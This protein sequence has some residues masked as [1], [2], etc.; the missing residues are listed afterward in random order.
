M[1]TRKEAETLMAVAVQ[2][3]GVDEIF[4]SLSATDMRSRSVAG[5]ALQPPHRMSNTT[6]SVTVRKGKRYAM[7]SGN[8]VEEKDVR[9]LVARA[10]EN[11]AEM[12]EAPEIVA[13]P[14]AVDVAEAPLFTPDDSTASDRDFAH[15][16]GVMKADPGSGGTLAYGSVSSA[17]SMLALASSNGLFVY[18]PSS[19]GHAQF[20]CYSS[21]GRSTGFAE[22]YRQDRSALAISA[23]LQAAAESCRSWMNPVE[24]A[25]KRITTIFEPRALADMLQ[26]LLRQFSTRAIAQDQSFLRRMD[27]G[28][29]LGSAMFDARISLRSDPYD[30]RLPSMPF[31]TDGEAVR[32][33]HW[34]KNGV[35][36]QLVI[37]RYEAATGGIRSVAPPTNLIMEVAEPVADLIA[38][39]EYGLLVR[40]FA[41]L[42][43]LDPKN[44]LLS[45][46]TRD[47]LF[48][49]EKG[50]ITKAVRNLVIRET[51]VY[52]F[53]ELLALGTPQQ[54]SPTG[55]YLPMLLP[56]I[57]VKDVMYT[58]LSGLV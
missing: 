31:T 19:L 33:E 52:M 7:A 54:T 57:K 40:G 58:Q 21:D 39:T 35:I 36:S 44:C 45:G 25:P 37:D 56:P 3:P 2:S 17:A 43:I 55:S 9:A 28:N 48:L 18:Q 22:A 26:P 41:N 6:I 50:K 53:K 8:V 4:V 23:T 14:G 42:N 51:P 46:S 47:G 34:V 29:F 27:G 30:A 13:F 12:P 38:D 24:I 5:A 32:A 10:M 15:A 49:I 1:I 20:R 16:V 11:A